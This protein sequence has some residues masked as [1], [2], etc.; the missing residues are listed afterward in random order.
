MK[1]LSRFKGRIIVMSRKSLVAGISV[2]SLLLVYL[3]FNT[4]DVSFALPRSGSKIRSYSHPVYRWSISYPSDW[5]LNARDPG[6]V[7]ISY[8]NKGLCGV[9]TGAVPFKTVDEFTDFML[10]KSTKL[11]LDKGFLTIVS[12]RRQISLPND[13]V[14][15]DVL[16]D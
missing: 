7:L 4:G 2:L 6:H 13:I 10:N 15:N 8:K 3:L 14:G 12:L 16:V 1:T 11:L 9:H 5:K